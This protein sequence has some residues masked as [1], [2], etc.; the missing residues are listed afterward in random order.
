MHDD[1]NC[2]SLCIDAVLSESYFSA[3]RALMV[4]TWYLQAAKAK[5]EWVHFQG[6]QLLF[7]FLSFISLGVK[8]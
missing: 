7:S 6:K 3:C 4:H 8:S 5:G 1:S 2:T